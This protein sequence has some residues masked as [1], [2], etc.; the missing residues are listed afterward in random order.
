[1]RLSDSSATISKP[2]VSISMIAS[3][4]VTRHPSLLREVADR[5]F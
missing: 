1:M 3:N 2:K 5:P 4:T